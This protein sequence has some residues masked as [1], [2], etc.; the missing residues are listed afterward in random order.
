MNNTPSDAANQTGILSQDELELVNDLSL[1]GSLGSAHLNPATDTM[2][3]ANNA[4]ASTS[5]DP[6]PHIERAEYVAMR[7][8]SPRMPRTAPPPVARDDNTQ[9]DLAKPPAILSIRVGDRTLAAS[10][11]A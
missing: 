7:K 5:R 4:E 2:A 6:V 8:K 1:V 9:T 11:K 3:E 10:S